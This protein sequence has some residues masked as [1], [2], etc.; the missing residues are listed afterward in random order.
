MG[1]QRGGIL[2]QRHSR[3][4]LLVAHWTNCKAEP[5]EM[6]E[7]MLHMKRNP[8]PGRVLQ[9]YENVFCPLQ[10]QHVIDQTERELGVTLPSELKAFY[11]EIGE[12]Q[13]QTGTNGHVSDF[14]W[15]AGPSEL[16]KIVQGESDWLMPYS[17]LEPNTLPFFQRD[18]DLFLCLHPMSNN[19]N[20]V[21]WMWGEKMPNGGKICDS[22]V[23]FFQ[24]LVD[25]PNWFNLPEP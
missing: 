11:R 5:S 9:L 2:R 4:I 1:R 25:D 19:P 10:D 3:A 16:V 20:A 17:Q 12:G 13:L 21:W 7:F 15:V 22:L 24:R 6:Y 23:E 18:V 8:E 14:N